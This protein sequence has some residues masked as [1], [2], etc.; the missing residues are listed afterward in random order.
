MANTWG[1]NRNS[2]KFYFLTPESLQMVTAGKRHLP[3][4]RKAMT[5]LDNILKKQRHYFANKGLYSQSYGFS[6]SHVCESWTIKEVEHQGID[7]FELWC[8]R[9]FLKSLGQQGDPTSQS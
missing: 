1:N 6:S 8:Q 9:R 4:G 5:N 7:A 2:D 3:L